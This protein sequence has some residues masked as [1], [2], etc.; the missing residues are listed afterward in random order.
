MRLYLMRAKRKHMTIRW[1]LESHSFQICNMVECQD[2]QEQELRMYIMMMNMKLWKQISELNRKAVHK[3]I[4]VKI[5]RQESNFGKI[6]A[7][8]KK[9]E[10]LVK[11]RILLE[12]FGMNLMN[13]FS[14]RMILMHQEMIQK[15]L[16]IK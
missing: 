14:L 6:L 10:M 8:N 1:E 3:I 15:E 2:K 13:S 12:R 9:K 11:R 16:I 7:T 4:G 5:L